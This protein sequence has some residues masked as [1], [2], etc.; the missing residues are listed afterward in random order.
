M[1]RALKVNS[2][3]NSVV[4]KTDKET[5]A[6]H[7]RFSIHYIIIKI[8]ARIIL[9]VDCTHP[10]CILI[11]WRG[12][13]VPAIHFHLESSEEITFHNSPSI[14]SGIVSSATNSLNL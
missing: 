6:N 12:G 10:S 9:L 11:P 2:Y 13:D 1:N 4:V 8:N 7:K 5:Y 3:I 14:V